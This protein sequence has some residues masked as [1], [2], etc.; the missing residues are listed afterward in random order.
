MKKIIENRILVWLM[1]APFL[2]LF[3]LPVLVGWTVIQLV[4]YDKDKKKYDY[5]NTPIQDRPEIIEMNKPENLNEEDI[6]YFKSHPQ[7]TK[8]QKWGYL[9]TN[10]GF[11]AYIDERRK[12]R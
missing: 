7:Y 11:Y 3:G 10:S 6:E 9:K 12:G 5:Y 8:G 1:F 2:F 4:M